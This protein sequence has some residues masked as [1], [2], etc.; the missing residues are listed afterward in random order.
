MNGDRD[1]FCTEAMMS[2]LWSNGKHLVVDNLWN[3]WTTHLFSF[4]TRRTSS[5]RILLLPN[6]EKNSITV[7][8][9]Q[10]YEFLMQLY[11]L[12]IV[13]RQ[14]LQALNSDSFE[15]A[16]RNTSQTDL[17]SLQ[18]N[19]CWENSWGET[20]FIWLPIVVASSDELFTLL[21]ILCRKFCNL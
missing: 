16:A 4:A 10:S 13:L 15:P 21:T 12:V 18:Q 8:W 3:Q 5:L 6:K 1:H 9:Y 17:S 20:K 14:V 11:M 7:S 2:K 19:S